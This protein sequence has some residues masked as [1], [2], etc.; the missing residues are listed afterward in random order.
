MAGA[1]AASGAGDRR[2]RARR[3]SFPTTTVRGSCSPRPRGR[4]SRAT[5]SGRGRASSS[6]RAHDSA[7]RAALDLAEAGC[8]I[9]MIAD[10][11]AEAEGPLPEAARR[12]GLRVETDAA[13]LGSYGGAARHP[14][15]RRQALERRQAGQGRADRLRRDRDE[16]RL[17]A[18]RQPAFAVARRPRLRRGDAEFPP[19]RRGRRTSVRR[20][21]AAAFSI[22][23]AVLADG[24]RRGRRGGGRAG[25]GA[26]AR[27][28][29][30]GGQGR[31][32]RARRGDEREGA[33]QGL[34]RFPERRHRARHP[35]G[36]AR[37]HALDRAHQALHHRRHGDRP[38]QDLQ[39]ERAR[40]RRRGA[41]QADRRGRPDDVPPALRAGDLRRLRRPGA[42][43]TV[44]SRSARRRCTRGRRARAPSSKRRACGSA[45]PISPAEA[46]AAD[47]AVRREQLATRASAGIM[48]ASTLGK[49]EVVG[50]DAA[51]FLE[52]PLR[53]FV[54]QAR[55]RALPLRPDAG[56]GRLHRRR[57]RRHAARR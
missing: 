3:W 35:I 14:R 4:L 32:A 47:E 5:A 19:R 6:R 23:A 51:E 56:R 31:R 57:R 45:P 25:A 28:G 55:G 36:G 38:G 22:S 18:E 10:L 7:Y 41:R 30:V 39:P 8:E 43:R 53:Q 20:A 2:A 50:P 24:V 48:D 16:R 27:R 44:R 15:A 37:G 13:I 29:R 33:R 21:P 34:R 26:A 1:R 46:R 54:R 40:H 49:I 9:A 52:S 42:A 17:D 12:A 11:R